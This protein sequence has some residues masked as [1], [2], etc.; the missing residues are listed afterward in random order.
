VHSARACSIGSPWA[1]TLPAAA[2]GTGATPFGGR[3]G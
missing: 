2:G 1:A 3:S